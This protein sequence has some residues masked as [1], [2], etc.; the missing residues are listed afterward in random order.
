MRRGVGRGLALVLVAA[1]MAGSAVTAG[2]AFAAPAQAPQVGECYN[3]S[4]A[5]LRAGG[6]WAETAAVPCSAPHTFQVTEVGPLPQDANAFTFAADQ[7]GA[8][9]VWTEVGVNVPEAGV[10]TAPLRIQPWSFAVRQDA[11]SY[12]CGAVAVDL[13]GVRP[14]TAV[15]L[16]SS[17]ERLSDRERAALRY[18]GSAA[19]GRPA[20]A[21]QVTVPC[22]QRPRW[23]V[24][25][26]VMWSAFYDAYPDRAVLKQRARALCGPGTV[27][28]L[29]PAASWDAGTARTWCYRLYP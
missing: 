18:C 9:D 15:T 16:T 23:E 10:V 29:P 12:L 19:D 13:A 26:W 20:R 17:I 8:L 5:R 11:G 1:A 22:T 28:S 14:P 4:D 3:L 2:S 21:P 25:A 24:T 7:C 27:A 6:W